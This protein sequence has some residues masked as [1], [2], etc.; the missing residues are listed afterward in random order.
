M[1]NIKWG[2][3]FKKNEINGDQLKDYLQY[4][5]RSIKDGKLG[6]EDA[7]GFVKW[8]ASKAKRGC[9]YCKIAQGNVESV[10]GKLFKKGK[11]ERGRWLEIDRTDPDNTIYDKDNCVLACYPC[12]NAKSNVFT[13]KDFKETIGPAITE[14]C[15]KLKRRRH[16][17][18]IKSKR[19]VSK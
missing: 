17:P 14:V 8:Y 7:S 19:V 4:K 9:Y 15:N 3:I 16:R 5:W 11:G 18:F 1:S 2:T 6:W 10:Y 13:E 12:N